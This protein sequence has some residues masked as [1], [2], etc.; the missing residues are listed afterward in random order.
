MPRPL[1]TGVYVR[2]SD[3]WR[4]TIKD[5]L[6]AAI[7]QY[8]PSTS[9]VLSIGGKLDGLGLLSSATIVWSE[10]QVF[11][12]FEGTAFFEVHDR[13]TNT[14]EEVFDGLWT[15]DDPDPLGRGITTLSVEG[16]HVLEQDGP[17]E[18][19]VPPRNLVYTDFVNLLAVSPPNLDENWGE[20][21]QSIINRLTDDIPDATWGVDA[22]RR[23]IL[24]RAGQGSRVPIGFCDFIEIDRGKYEITPYVTH[25]RSDPGENLPK[26][27]GVS[28][29]LR[30]PLTPKRLG[31]ISPVRTGGESEEIT[32]AF[33]PRM[34]SAS[35]VNTAPP[36]PNNPPPLLTTVSNLSNV[37]LTG[38]SKVLCVVWD[39]QQWYQ[40]SVLYRSGPDYEPVSAYLKFDVVM[41]DIPQS[42]DDYEYPLALEEAYWI[43][44]KSQVDTDAVGEPP[45]SGPGLDIGVIH[46]VNSTA[47]KDILRQGLIA[48]QYIENEGKRYTLEFPIPDETFRQ[49]QTER[50]G[51]RWFLQMAVGFKVR[52]VEKNAGGDGR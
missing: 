1:V 22:Q 8:D 15:L 41:T 23:V 25:W 6:G 51:G 37:V 9:K 45:A 12:P 46:P 4:L 14:W 19:A 48:E 38:K 34:L 35:V 52:R 10:P 7:A 50:W 5:A 17:Y 21:N 2:E 28:S 13:A 44:S 30:T 24:G 3:N 42:T 47:T 36:P 33:G 26:Q 39:F 40:E 31:V 32:S 43:S 29:I 16:L 11:E 27:S 18:G 20:T 49:D